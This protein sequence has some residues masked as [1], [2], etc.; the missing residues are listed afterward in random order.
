MAIG[1]NEFIAN[2]QGGGARPNLYR[3]SF[4]KFMDNPQKTSFMCKAASLP[5]STMGV[6]DV[7]YMGR[8]IKIAG[9]KTFEPW[10]VT[11]YEDTDFVS[12]SSF[13]RWSA[14]M[15]THESNVGS[16]NPNDYYSDIIVEQ[17]DRDGG[18]V[19]YTYTIKN[20]FPTEVGEISLGYAEN[21]T[22]EEFQVTFE[23]NYW[24]SDTI[25]E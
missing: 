12:K 25:S 3:I 20:A 8:K 24:F 22:V 19:L 1:I 16:T 10:T 13:E 2:F 17:L 9:D 11:I 18:K 21:D 14:L 23:Y 4:T 15:N 7:S 5:P 6:A